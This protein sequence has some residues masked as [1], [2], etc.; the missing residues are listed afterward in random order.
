V[1]PIAPE[2]YL[3]RV[4]LSADAHRKLERARDLLRHS[5]PNGD[6]AAIV[7]RALTVLVEQLERTKSARLPGRARPRG[8]RQRDRDTCRP[9]SGAKSGREMED[10]ARLLAQAGA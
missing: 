5:I 10:D 4:T 7:D 9:R 2:R 3:M 6:P 8:R 1:A